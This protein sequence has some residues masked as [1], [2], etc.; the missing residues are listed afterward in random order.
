MTQ[1]DLTLPGANAP[2]A[3]A[4]TML[5]SMAV[6]GVI[7]NVVPLLA[8]K[9]GVWQFFV[10]RTTLSV[11][12]IAILAIWGMGAMFPR[13]WGAVALRS[14]L[15][16]ISMVF[17][18]IALGLMPIAQAIAG[19]FTSPVIIV[20]ISV[21]FMGLRIG[22]VRILAILLGFTGTL[23]VLQPDPNDFDWMILVPVAGGFFYAL[24]SIATRSMCEGES[25]L[26]MLLGMLLAQAMLGGFA[27]VGLSVWPM[28]VLPGADGFVTRSWVWPVWDI[29]PWII[30]HAVGSLVGVFLLIKAYQLGEPSF[31]AVFE[32]SV[33]IVGSGFAW[34]V[35]GQ[36]I[37]AWQIFGIGLII[38]AGAVIA[39]RSEPG[40]A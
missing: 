40:S 37:D 15:M 6:I 36:V 19:L 33:M 29:S 4:N 16:G 11:P 35:Y 7:D 26:S 5:A 25:T 22:K 1:S 13:R 39:L 28:E 38:L 3:A 14:L 21:L 8:E 27:L 32:Y 34:M 30:V 2:F 10:M 17:Y 18:F 9:V 20:V 31:V 23:F 12:M 24:G